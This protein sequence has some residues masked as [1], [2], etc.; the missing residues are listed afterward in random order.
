MSTR[1]IAIV[2]GYFN[3][4]HVGHVRLMED[5]LNYGDQ[6]FVIVNNDEQQ[7]MKKGKVITT[8][9]DR[10]EVVRAIGMVS[11][12]FPA[13]DEDRTV[14]ATLLSIAQDYPARQITF[15]NGGDRSDPRDVPEYYTC[16]ENGLR[17]VFEVGGRYKADSSSRINQALGV[18]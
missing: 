6:L 10:M 12:A 9:A 8:L 13:I 1:S 17:M 11:K 14:C 4:L 16:Q 3:P 15:C 2:S 7:L 18:E 5:A